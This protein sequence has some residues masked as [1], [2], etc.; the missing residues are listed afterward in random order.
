VETDAVRETSAAISGAMKSVPDERFQVALPCCF[1]FPCLFVPYI[2]QFGMQRSQF[3]GLMGDIAAG[4][5]T[6]SES[7]VHAADGSE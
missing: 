4:D 3:A 2:V 7:G 5:A 1:T 6:L